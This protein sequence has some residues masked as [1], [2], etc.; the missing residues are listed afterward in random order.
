MAKI[1]R[2]YL[3]SA[4]DDFPQL[5]GLGIAGVCNLQIA[6]LGHNVLSGERPPG[7]PPPRVGPPLLDLLDLLLELSVLGVDVGHDVVFGMT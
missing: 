6:S 1:R 5:L 2:V 3:E 4:L 7:V